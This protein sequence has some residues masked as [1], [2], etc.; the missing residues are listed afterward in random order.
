MKRNGKPAITPSLCV[1]F[2][3]SFPFGSPWLCALWMRTGSTM[4]WCF[5]ISTSS[6]MLNDLP[7]PNPGDHNIVKRV[8][9]LQNTSL[10]VS[11]TT[12]WCFAMC[13]DSRSI[14]NIDFFTFVF[15]FQLQQHQSTSS[16]PTPLPT[17]SPST[18]PL[19]TALLSTTLLPTAP[20]STSPLPTLLSTTSLPAALPSTTPLPTSYFAVYTSPLPAA[21][22]PTPLPAASSPPTT[23]LPAVSPS[24]SSLPTPLPQIHRYA[25][26]DAR[27]AFCAASMYCVRAS[28]YCLPRGCALCIYSGAICPL[29]CMLRVYVTVLFC[30]ASMSCIVCR[31]VL[32]H[33]YCLPRD[34]ALCIC[35]CC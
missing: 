7:P 22:L 23:P 11:F 6:Y 19:P 4:H 12:L 15:L 32:V 25:D 5:A 29:L 27:I 3:A 17:A 26:I 33:M 10:E 2:V 13:C 1:L 28:M 35:I 24:T 9:W 16:L 34:C 31:Y 18:T 20:P 8:S 21:S 14:V 30:A